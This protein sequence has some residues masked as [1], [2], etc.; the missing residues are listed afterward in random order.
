MTPKL[1]LVGQGQR[2]PDFSRLDADGRPATFFEVR[3][4]QPTVLLLLGRDAGSQPI[5]T[6]WSART[7]AFAV[8]GPAVSAPAA[9]PK[10]VRD[11]GAVLQALT[12]A[13]DG[14]ALWLLDARLRLRAVLPFDTPPAEALARLQALPA[15]PDLPAP[16]LIAPEVLPPELCDRLIA[17]HEADNAP[18]GMLRDTGNGVGLAEDG[19][20]KRRRDHTLGDPNLERAVTDALARRLLPDIGRAFRFR[21]EGYERFKVVAYDAAEGGWFRAH[22]DNTTPDAARRAFALTLNLNEGYEGGGLVFP[23]FGAHAYRPEAGGAAVFSCA[24][25]HAAEPVTAGRRYVLLTFFTGRGLEAPSGETG[26]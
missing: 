16:V 26:S 18:S 22:R 2:L 19:A 14:R 17:A 5:L 13:P 12:G 6:A 20:V 24:L 1:G 10:W 8:L 21:V 9:G 15:P 25:L 23:E 11:D 3:C 7:E 4:G